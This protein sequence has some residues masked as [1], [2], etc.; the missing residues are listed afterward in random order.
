[1]GPAMVLAWEYLSVPWRGIWWHDSMTHTT[2]GDPWRG[3]WLSITLLALVSYR[4]RRRGLL[5]RQLFYFGAASTV[6]FAYRIAFSVIPENVVWLSDRGLGAYTLWLGVAAVAL[7]GLCWQ[8]GQFRPPPRTPNDSAVLA[9]HAENDSNVT[10]E[11]RFTIGHLILLVTCIAASLAPYRVYLD[12]TDAP[13]ISRWWPY[14]VLNWVGGIGS[15]AGLCALVLFFARQRSYVVFPQ[16]P[17]EYVAVTIGAKAAINTA[18][19]LVHVGVGGGQGQLGMTSLIWSLYS[20][21][22]MLAALIYLLP[23]RYA[24]HRVWRIVFR[25]LVAINVFGAL[26]GYFDFAIA[27]WLVCD[28]VLSLLI[29]AAVIV[30]AVGRRQRPWVHWLGIGLSFWFLALTGASF[31]INWLIARGVLTPPH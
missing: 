12:W 25:G 26:F 27:A 19:L 9:D 2:Y 7:G 1:L 31:A 29:L 16:H 5:P 30:D 28:A 11:D 20:V 21:A 23:A 18:A 4:L 24:E 3:V 14:A 6:L 17:G 15:G 10:H 8:A 13:S 22:M